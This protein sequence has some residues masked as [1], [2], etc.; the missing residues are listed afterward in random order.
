MVYIGVRTA[1]NL[2]GKDDIDQVQGLGSCSGVITIGF[3]VGGL[4]LSALPPSMNFIGKFI[5]TSNYGG[6][7][8]VIALVAAGAFLNLAAFLR[9]IRKVFLGIPALK[10]KKK[11][12]SEE[13]ITVILIVIS[14]ILTFQSNYFVKFL[15]AGVLK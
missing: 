6:S 1:I 5:T 10:A 3:I 8:V 12:G 4:M 9:V 15:E 2:T 11:F 14:I 13:L 7:T